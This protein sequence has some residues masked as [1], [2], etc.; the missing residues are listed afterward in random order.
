MPCER[1]I[2]GQIKSLLIICKPRRIFLAVEKENSRIGETMS[3]LLG[4]TLLG[5]TL[6]GIISQ[7]VL[8]ASYYHYY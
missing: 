2:Y 8:L 4:A 6:L 3:I 7:T 1:M 5:A